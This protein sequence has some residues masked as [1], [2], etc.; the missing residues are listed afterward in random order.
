MTESFGLG[1]SPEILALGKRAEAAVAPI[2][3]RIDRI[4]AA[5]TEKVLEAFR[6]FRVSAS[7][8]TGT[9]GYGYDDR[10]RDD[11]DRIFARV[12]GAE[13]AL[14]R[15][16]FV[17]GTHALTTCMFGILR[18]GDVLLSAVGAP[19]DTLQTAIGLTGTASGSLMD[20]GIRYAQTEPAEGGPDLEAIAA[21][22]ADPAV[23]MVWLQRSRGYSDR[24]ALT[25][26]QLGT[27][28]ELVHRVNP[29]AVVMVDNCYG[30][31][32]RTVEPTQLGADLMAGSLIK[33]PGGGLAPVGGYIAGRR[34]LVE[35]CAG[36][37]TVP[38]IGGE[39]GA[40]LDTNRLLYQGFFTAPHTTAQAMKT[41]VFCAKMT[42]LMGIA[43]S[44]AADEDRSDIVQTV[45]FGSVAGLER[46]CLGIQ[47]G[48]P[49]DS[50]VTPE[51]WDMPGYADPVIMAAGA[52]V[53][54]ASIELSC[55]GPM[56][57]PYTAY[58]QGGL[59]WE[60]GRLG[61]LLALDEVRKGED[62]L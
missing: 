25:P 16:Q 44:P 37:L 34:E 61:I 53:Q 2:F 31:F 5:N 7:H 11:L 17:N 3:E 58:L 24:P 41:A 40:S 43:H 45:S 13:A 30:E 21:A 48:A 50:Y 33:N 55:D 6:T 14:V 32:T 39:V 27:I 26:E 12:F 18:P 8:L 36:R 57:P 23:R 59:T 38:G 51:A 20:F 19:Y 49:V 28:A 54:G 62:R 29:R 46:F 52:F 22:A 56:R 1:L 47:K 9:T 10:G 42:E 4:A 35:Q 60:S 15:Q